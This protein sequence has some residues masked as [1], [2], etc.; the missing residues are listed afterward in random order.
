MTQLTQ[1]QQR[2]RRL[3]GP[4]IEV[5]KQAHASFQDFVGFYG[6]LPAD[7]AAL[8]QTDLKSD[9][10]GV[11]NRLFGRNMWAQL[12]VQAPS[13]GMLAK[14][15]R[16]KTSTLGWRAK[17]AFASSGKGGQAEGTIPAAVV[18]T[19]FEVSPT[20][21]EHSTQMR[22]SGMLQDLQDVD[23]AYGTLEE[24]QGEL[25]VEHA[26]EFERALNTDIDT[27]AG[28]NVESLDRVPA[29]S[30][31]QATVGWTAGDEDIFG[32]DRSA[33]TWADGEQTVN[34]TAAALT[35]KA[36]D[37][38]FRR[39]LKNGGQPTVWHTGFDTWEAIADLYD[40]RGRYEIGGGLMTGVQVNDA[41]AA[42]GLAISTFVGQLHGRPIVVTDQAIADSNE[43]SRVNLFDQSNPEG[44]DKPRL[45][46]DVIRPTQFYLAGE[47]STRAPQTIS[48]AGDSVLAVTRGQVG[49]RFFKA[50]GQDRDRT[51]P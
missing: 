41:K 10:T 2:M 4:A 27:T 19:Y 8:L 21:K 7:G 38:L 24:I 20:P 22:V 51:A 39:V 35:T 46:F 15:Q 48:F 33:N 12:N 18:S 32:I 5:L 9:A 45:G 31:N 16:S 14:T 42:D 29:S 11:V 25:A 26:K 44:Y 28:N 36:L 13:F 40:P 47:R 3:R 37:S 34:A 30:A 17:T 49:C 6:E 43:I 23:D 1:N 50:Q